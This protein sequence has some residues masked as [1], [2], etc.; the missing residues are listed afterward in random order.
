MQG[1]MLKMQFSIALQ[2]LTHG[3]LKQQNPIKLT[4]G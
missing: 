1:R 2:S 4:K 3:L